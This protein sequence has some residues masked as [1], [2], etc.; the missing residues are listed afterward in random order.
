MAITG[1]IPLTVE[2]TDS[3]TGDN[4]TYLWDFGD[5]QTSIEQ[6][7]SHEYT[8]AGDYSVSLTTSNNYGSDIATN[9]VSATSSTTDGGDDDFDFNG[10]KG[11]KKKG[12]GDDGLGK[13]KGKA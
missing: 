11:G 10:K 1:N 13:K 4:L 2:F 9:T 6:N 5:G 7:P 3:S 8:V 12:N